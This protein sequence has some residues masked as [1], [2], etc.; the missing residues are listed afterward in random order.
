MRKYLLLMLTILMGAMWSSVDAKW[1]I[2]ERKSASQ[3]KAGDTIVLEQAS[4]D[5]YLGYY[6]QAVDTENG[7]ECLE[8]IGAGSA[9]VLV[10]EEGPLDIRT[11]EATVYIKLLENGKYLGKNDNW[12]GDEGCG[13]VDDIANAANFQIIS[14]GEPIPWSN[15]YGWDDYKSEENYKKDED[16]TKW[17]RDRTTGEW[18]NSSMYSKVQNW[19]SNSSGRGSD[20]ES[21]GLCWSK[22]T[23]SY[24]YLGYWSSMK[25]KVILWT[26]TDTNQWNAYSATYE[27]S[28]Q[29]DLSELI[30][31]YMDEGDY[32]P[33]TDPGFYTEESVDAYNT[34]MQQALE[35]SVIGAT[36]DEYIAAMDALKAAH[37]SLLSSRNPL[38]DGYYYFVVAFEAYL[39]EYGHEKAAYVNE[40]KKQLYQ[41]TFD[42]EN[43]DFVFEVTK[44]EEDNEYWVKSFVTDMYVGT[45][46]D[47]YGQSIPADVEK[48]EPQNLRYYTGKCTGK[49][50]WS[51]HS[52][53]WCSYT[54][55][56]GNGTPSDSDG[57]LWNWGQWGDGGV[58]S[59]QYNCWYLRK[60]TDESVLADFEVQ[61]AQHQ[62]TT[63]LKKLVQEGTDLYGKLFVYNPDYTTKLI[64]TVSGGVNEEPAEDNQLTFSSIST[65]GVTFSDKYEFLIDDDDTTYMRGSGYIRIKLKEPKQI[66]TFVYNTRDPEGRGSNPEWQQWGEE[67][68]PALIDLYAY[69]TV[70][71]DSVF[72]S[73]ITTGIDMS[74]LPLP[75]TYTFNF[76]RPVDRIAFYVTK[77]AS[78]S[79]KFSISE[80]QMY[81]AKADEAQ[82]QYYTT[83]G[84]AP[85]ADALNE[86]LPTMR[87]IVSNN[88]ATDE[89]IETM[90]A[91]IE[92][93]KGMYADTTEL[94][95]LIA[96]AEVVLNGT[97]VGD[98]M[99]Q[100][101]DQALADAL[102]A[103][104][105]D[106]RAN[107]FTAPVSLAA[108]NAAIT[109]VTE[110]KNNF[111]AGIKSIEEGKWY[112]IVNNDPNTRAG[113]AGAEDSFC[114]GSAIYFKKKETSS[115]L[116]KW[117][118]FDDASMTLNAE[119]NPKAMW[120]FV[121][122]EGTDYYA[123]QNLYTGYY[124][125]DYAGDD[126]NL[127]YS[128][129]PVPYEIAFVGHGQ[130]LLYPRGGNNKKN[131][132]L[133]PEGA[134][135][136]VVCHEANPNTASAWTFIEID[137]EEQEAISISDF[138]FN[139]IDVMAVPYAIKDIAE[140]NE[141]VHTYAIKKMT[142]EIQN[143]DGVEQ[144]VTTV[145]LYEKNEFAAGEPCILALGDW[146]SSEEDAPFE[147]FD[148]LI[149]FPTGDIVDHTH[150][151]VANG[152]VGSLHSSTPE[153]ITAVSTGKEFVPFTSGFGAQTG[154]ID[155]STYRGEVTGV[156]TAATLVII[157]ELNAIS[158]RDPADVNGDG[159]KNT[160]DVVAVYTF[161]EQGAAS[162]FAREA[163]D[164]NRDTNVNTADVVAIYTAIIGNA[165]SKSFAKSGGFYPGA[166]TIDG[167]DNV[168]T[169][170]VESTDDLAK[171]PVTLYLTNPTNGITAVE[172]TLVAPVDVK[173]FVYDEEE[174][175]FVYDPGT[176]W[177]KGHAPMLA[178]GTE[179]HG[180][181]GF[182]ISIADSKTRDFKETEGAIITVYFDGS[183]LGDGDYTVKMKDA[184]SV[185]VGDITYT[186]ADVDAA[187]SIKDGKVTAVNSAVIN[188][189]A[190]A[191]TVYGVDGKKVTSA[192]KGQIYVIDGK[193]VK[194]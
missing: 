183:D 58:V 155:P 85:K 21:I 176:R 80:F 177:T 60:I 112:Y 79:S 129:T 150:K 147:D 111:M 3:L 110:A 47:W 14:C 139:L 27:K 23:D 15:V 87:E 49:W 179:E 130:F 59:D 92:A 4:R 33:G 182:F 163:A 66:L 156:E 78:G 115:S 54:Y 34:A 108:V 22:R 159:N 174:E 38:T 2:G 166:E 41:K 192:Q 7:V 169:I 76:G 142:Q 158:D 102:R 168:L 138:S 40:A 20:D 101:S 180:A 77:N 9:S 189:A 157:G 91:A 167:S 165:G 48:D 56:S 61:K 186:S 154:V 17:Y 185:A 19:E 119:N 164:V 140:V 117:G 36:D 35:T 126:I 51:S 46:S 32:L 144:M 173:K 137:P 93:V 99:G 136:D 123:I 151:F 71:G 187:F 65:Q 89:N 1:I 98:G 100:L 52:Q 170:L 194:F 135:N 141:G 55:L 28:L 172:A 10:L 18:F 31:A 127:P 103:A 122:V 106:A 128:E 50:F 43:I 161:I 39:N 11:G 104:I 84:L 191:K 30:Q 8:G 25:P 125:G 13:L 181:D 131:F 70:A 113:E 72:G 75:A 94:A 124:M 134:D 118:L 152:I 63:E 12:S 121:A 45:P 114:Y 188:G 145:E 193:T 132:A 16:G 88:T 57:D 96:E 5:K 105:T 133:W 116:T 42:P 109:A 62:R 26:Y 86:I 74:T 97:E 178:A 171:I 53:Y 67:Q 44:A 83:E 175:D 73:A 37:A 6:L 162:G 148:L 68:R 120:R 190:A 143:I 81:E 24:K 184:I 149:P 95:A 153:P 69:N 82:S 146:E 107:A 29:D 160:A 90:R 64:T